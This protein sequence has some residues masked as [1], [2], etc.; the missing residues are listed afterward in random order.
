MRAVRQVRPL[1][2]L[3]IQNTKAFQEVFWNERFELLSHLHLYLEK[4][5]QTDLLFDETIK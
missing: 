4:I 2:Q 5:F 1:E 3:K